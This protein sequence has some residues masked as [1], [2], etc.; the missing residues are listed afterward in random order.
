MTEEELVE[1]VARAICVAK[2]LNPDEWTFAEQVGAFVMWWMIY[3]GAARAAIAAVRGAGSDTKQEQKPIQN[4]NFW[5]LPLRL[6]NLLNDYPEADIRAA[7]AFIDSLG[8]SP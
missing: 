1:K 2:G 5:E 6:Q 8:E 4:Q 7:L 3:D